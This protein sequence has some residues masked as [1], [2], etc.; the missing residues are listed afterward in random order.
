MVE[1]VQSKIVPERTAQWAIE[2]YGVYNLHSGVTT[3]MSEGFNTVIKRFLKWKEVPVDVL[4]HS[5]QELQSYHLNEIQRAMCGLGQY[6]LRKEFPHY[7]RSADECISVPASCPDDIMKNLQL[8][9][10]QEKLEVSLATSPRI[11]L[12]IHC[13]CV[14]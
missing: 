5:L 10:L 2:K 8:P 7:Q 12:Y 4:V 14:Q 11:A 13:Y 3:N 9:T 1:H 6:H